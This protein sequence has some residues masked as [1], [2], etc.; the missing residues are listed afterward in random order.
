[1]ATPS[2]HVIRVKGTRADVRRLLA[3]LPFVSTSGMTT[4]GMADVLLVRMG[5]ALLAKIKKAFIVKARGGSD[6]SG[7]KWKPLHPKTIAYKRRHPGLPPPSVRAGFRPSWILDDHQRRMWWGIY[8]KYVRKFKGDKSHAAAT[9]WFLLKRMGATTILEEYG[10]RPVEI[11]RDTG[12][13][14]NSL[15]PAV[16]QPAMATTPGNVP[17]QVFRTG[18]KEVIVGT[19]RK[20][21]R[22]HHRGVPGRLPRRPL[23]P[24]PS[25]WPNSWWQAILEQGKQGMVDMILYLLQGNRR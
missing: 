15:S 12:L 9:A 21:A 8:K 2:E 7:L 24:D 14:L 10:N 19:K 25:R 5:M 20:G 4:G 18:K 11:L 16:E 1:M 6:E 22:A 23:W 3:R 13:L 17:E